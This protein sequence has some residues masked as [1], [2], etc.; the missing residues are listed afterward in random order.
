MQIC[1]DSNYDWPDQY[2]QGS[3]IAFKL[4]NGYGFETWQWTMQH[5]IHNIIYQLY[6]SLGYLIGNFLNFQPINKER[7]VKIMQ[8]LVAI[9]CDWFL[10]KIALVYTKKLTFITSILILSN[11]FYFSMMNRTYINSIETC[12]SVI[13]YYLW[14]IR[15]K[16]Y[17]YDMLSRTIVGLNFIIRTTSILV[18]AVIWPY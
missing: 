2:W 10:L 15:E 6:L 5:P 3:Q 8:V 9:L 12:L 13:A 18:W 11:W 16:R 7:M 17:K 4:A 1:C 14:L